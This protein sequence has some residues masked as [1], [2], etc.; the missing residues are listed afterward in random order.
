M[1]KPEPETIIIDYPND[2]PIVAKFEYPDWKS[3]FKLFFVLFFYTIAGGMLLAWFLINTRDLG[4]SSL[5]SLL[6]LVFYVITMLLTIRYALK[7]SKK[8]RRSPFN[9]SFNKVQS[10]LV[11][12]IIVSTLALVVGLEGISNLIPMPVA[13]QKLFEKAFTKNIFSLVT[14]V[15]A[16]PIMEEILCRGIILKGL[17][18]NYSPQKAILISAIFFGV[19]HLN[20]WQALPA[21]CGGLFLGWVFYKT[22]SVIPGMIIHATINATAS[23]FLFLPKHQQGFSSLLGM[24][25]YIVLCFFSALV[26]IGGCVIIQ[27]KVLPQI[28]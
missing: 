15:I 27:K 23:V 1:D 5:K 22:Q 19:I 25:Y 6:N 17:L 20:P 11:P 24:P 18:K 4:T 12:V 7:K 3:L 13:V 10:W 26:F 14:A 2:S 16:A 9:F 21:F 8:Q 28:D